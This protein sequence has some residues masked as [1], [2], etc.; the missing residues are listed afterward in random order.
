[1]QL[2]EGTAVFVRANGDVQVGMGPASTVLTGLEPVEQS[3]LQSLKFHSSNTATHARAKKRNISEARVHKLEDL[4][5][6]RHLTQLAA[7]VQSTSDSKRLMRRDGTTNALGK[8]EQIRVDIAAHSCG[9]P[10]QFL[11][12]RTYL[13]ALVESLRGAS[14]KRLDLRYLGDDMGNSS[15]TTLNRSVGLGK[16]LASEPHL[17]IALFARASSYSLIR[18]WQDSGVPL[19]SVVFNE[20]N[21]QVGP[22]VRTGGSPCLECVDRNLR[23]VDEEWPALQVQCRHQPFPSLSPDLIAASA[24]MTARLVANE[25]DGYGL[26]PGEVRFIDENFVVDRFSWPIHRECSCTGL[27][28]SVKVPVHKQ[29]DHD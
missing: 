8:R 1:M 5:K 6:Q 22:F 19:L 16:P 29:S 20:D 12:M 28:A 10:T 7:E 14:I 9:D 2:R 13:T 23:D 26:P 18:E 4:L 25:I 15:R 27:P 21:V 24:M 17:I 3:Y 11:K